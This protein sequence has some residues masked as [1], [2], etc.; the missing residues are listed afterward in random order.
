[1]NKKLLLGIFVLILISSAYSVTQ[2]CGKGRINELCMITTPAATDC[3]SLDIVLSNGTIDLDDATPTELIENTGVY[4]ITYTPTVEGQ[5]NVI[6]IDNTSS[7]FNVIDIDFATQTNI[8]DTNTTIS[9]ID[10]DTE[11]TLIHGIG[12]WNEANITDVSNFSRDEL[13][14]SIDE[15]INE[16]HGTGSYQTLIEDTSNRIYWIILLIALVMFIIGEMRELKFFTVMAGFMLPILAIYSAEFGFI[17]FDN[18][19]VNTSFIILLCGI[20]FY[21]LGKTAYEL[22]TEYW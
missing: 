12:S 14:D 2:D 16:S 1:M 6:C 21:L 15:R 8:T 4:N 18:E 9:P 7:T 22:S 19:F 10:I 11:L 13:V 20:G 17:G 5:H 3:T